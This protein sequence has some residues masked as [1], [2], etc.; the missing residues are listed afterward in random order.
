MSDFDEKLGPKK[1]AAILALL[2]S[3]TDEEAARAVNVDPKTLSRWKKQPA[4][5]SALRKAE[6]ASFS[7]TIRSLNQLAGAAVTTIGKVMLDPKTPAA[8]K[9]RAADS[10]LSYTA[11]GMDVAE[12]EDRLVE[13][14]RRLKEN[15]DEK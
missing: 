11:K 15:T 1:T 4:F 8:T 12:M 5:A 13:V 14:E 7:Q 6:K 10:V 3:R 2:S 9:V